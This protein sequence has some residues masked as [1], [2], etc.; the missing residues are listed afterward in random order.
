MCAEAESWNCWSCCSPFNFS[1]SFFEQANID[2]IDF[3]FTDIYVNLEATIE[4]NYAD[5]STRPKKI[6][7]RGTTN[8][9]GTML[10]HLNINSIQNKFEE[11]TDMIKTLIA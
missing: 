4:G 3:N 8:V 7:A 11:L 9:Q 10:C 1:D 2:E 5:R 6:E